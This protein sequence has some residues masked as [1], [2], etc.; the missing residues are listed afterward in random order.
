MSDSQ[1]ELSQ[2][3]YAMLNDSYECSFYA[4]YLCYKVQYDLFTVINETVPPE[5]KPVWKEFI[6]TIRSHEEY[7][8]AARNVIREALINFPYSKIQFHPELSTAAASV[9]DDMSFAELFPAGK[10]GAWINLI[11]FH[12]ELEQYR[13]LKA[14]GKTG[15]WE[16]YIDQ[17]NGPLW[18]EVRHALH[19]ILFP[20]DFKPW[21]RSSLPTEWPFFLS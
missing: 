13:R 17:L 11:L 3:R 21:W 6:S 1:E 4:D 8:Q 5:I 2:M 9:S 19:D 7:R 16:Q 10:G 15:S 18:Q 20:L 14:A 12:I